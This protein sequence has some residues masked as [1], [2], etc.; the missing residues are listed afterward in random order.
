MQKATSNVITHSGYTDHIHQN[1]Y[2]FMVNNGGPSNSIKTLADAKK[3]WAPIFSKWNLTKRGLKHEG[4]TFDSTDYDTFIRKGADKFIKPS[5]SLRSTLLSLP[6]K[7]VLFTNSPEASARE[8][9]SLLGVLD[10]FEFIAGTD[11]QNNEH[12]K[13]ELEAFEKVLE[14]LS[15]KKGDEHKICYFEDSFKNLERGREM[16]MRTVFVRSETLEKEGRDGSETDRFDVVLNDVGLD[17]KEKVRGAPSSRLRTQQLLLYFILL[18]R[19]IRCF[20]P[21]LGLDRSALDFGEATPSVK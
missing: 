19:S 21:L 4:W 5:P 18:T 12:C 17:L 1:I 2:E 10:C 15:V 7:K 11:F 6:Q 20:A 14:K 8:C 3:A 9:L 16:G 13:P